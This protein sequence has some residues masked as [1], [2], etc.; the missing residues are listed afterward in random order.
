[1]GGKIDI[2]KRVSTLLTILNKRPETPFTAEVLGFRRERDTNS[3]D[4]RGRVG[5]TIY[6]LFRQHYASEI[7][8]TSKMGSANVFVGLQHCREP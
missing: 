8:P 5:E 3:I 2:M 6:Q 7:N 1:M 4:Q